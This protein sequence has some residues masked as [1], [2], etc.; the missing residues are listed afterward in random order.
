MRESKHLEY[1]EAVSNSF[2]KTVSAYANYGTGE[3]VFGISDDGTVKGIENPKAACL[4][5]ENRIND[6]IAPVP[7]YTLRVN[8]KTS[9]ITL[10]VSEGLYKPYLYKAKA[11]RRND[12]STIAVD[13]LA[14]SR[15]ILE[16][17]NLSFEELP[18]ES[19]KLTFHILE[20]KLKASLHLKEVSMDTLKTLELYKDGSGFNH[21]GELLADANGFCGVDIIRF[22]DNISVIRDRETYAKESVLQQ[23]DHALAMFIK[24]YRYEQIKGSYREPVFLIPEE[25]FREALANAIVRHVHG[26]NRNHFAR[27][28]A[29]RIG[30]GRISSG[31]HFDFE[32][33]H[34]GRRFP[35]PGH[36]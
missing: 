10:T 35:P 17:Q 3:I 14:L 31:R 5:I 32:T 18:A 13:R 27:R 26:S 22:G 23:Y 29:K 8:S 33:S 36:D 25:A 4:D 20:E 7:E 19:Q 1:K 34:P 2:L 15:L 16:G 24:Y 12:S 28:S 30:F 9:V 21:A 11:Y 6:S